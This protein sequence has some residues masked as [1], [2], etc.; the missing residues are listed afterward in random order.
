MIFFLFSVLQLLSLLCHATIQQTHDLTFSTINK[1]EL[2]MLNLEIS[3]YMAIPSSVIWAPVK[4]ISV[5]NPLIFYHQRKGGGS[6]IR[7]TIASVAKSAKFA[8]HIPCASNVPC[9]YYTI[10]KSP[11]YAAYGGHYTWPQRLNIEN[12]TDSI[13]CVTNFREPVSRIVSCLYYRHMKIIGNNCINSLSLKALEE[14]LWRRDSYGSSCLNEPFRILSGMVKSDE[15][16]LNHLENN[17]PQ[18]IGST[19]NTSRYLMTGPPLPKAS[20]TSE[21]NT[22]SRLLLHTNATSIFKH[23][24]LHLSKCSPLVLELPLSFDLA[25]HR[26]T[27]LWNSSKQLFMSELHSYPTKHHLTCDAPANEHLQMIALFCELETLLYNTIY[28]K[29]QSAINGSINLIG[30]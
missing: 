2:E 30:S 27:S 10:P 3:R 12:L 14:L 26:F 25:N 23:T 15:E 9:D 29:V 19:D 28:E 11:V 8:S 21:L 20:K 6:S 7:Q 1:A 16:L 5:K 13:T 18:W 22:R 4:E 17:S 24:L